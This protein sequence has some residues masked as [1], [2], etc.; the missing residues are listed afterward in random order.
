MRSSVESSGEPQGKL[1]VTWGEPSRTNRPATGSPRSK[2]AVAPSPG[3]QPSN[4][5]APFTPKRR[6]ASRPGSQ[7]HRGRADAK[8]PTPKPILR[9]AS[10][11]GSRSAALD[12][13][14]PGYLLIEAL[15][16]FAVIVALLGTGYAAMY[17]CIDSSIALRRNAEDIANALH[18][19]ER[20]RADE[21]AARQPVRLE[22]T[23]EG[24]LLYLPRAAT[25]KPPQSQLPGG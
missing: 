25:S 15:V 12:A 21:R 24:Q 3:R 7:R 11:D 2:T 17:R 14:Q 4:E 1:G 13:G 16:Y 6:T 20:W 5:D 8:S 19:G 18:A 23:A 22:D 10:R 9:A